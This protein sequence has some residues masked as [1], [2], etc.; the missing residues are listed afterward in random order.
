M[1]KKDDFARL[2]IP[3]PSA[4]A[5]WGH[6]LDE[7]AELLAAALLRAKALAADGKRTTG[8]TNRMERVLHTRS[9]P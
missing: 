9:N 6:R 3:Q 7:V 2:R 8:L 1:Q 4:A 5:P